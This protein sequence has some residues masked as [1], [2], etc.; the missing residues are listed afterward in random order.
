MA[1]LAPDEP[2]AHYQLG[3]LYKFAGKAAE[4]LA[5]FER[6]VRL[7]PRLAAARFQLYNMYR[8][9]GRTEEAAATLE[10]FQTLKKQSAG[11]AI[12]EDVDWCDY[13][14]IYDPPRPSAPTPATPE[15][16]FEDRPL[17]GAFDAENRGADRSSIPP[18]PARS[19]C[20]RGLHKACN[21]IAA[22]RTASPMPA[23]R[24]SPESSRSLP[25][26]LTTTA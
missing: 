9:A 24:V 13:A 2:I 8:Q 19:I 3:T 11:A 26:I 21:S 1:A 17:E 20:W 22:A 4:A 5:A 10:V 16:E 7:D 18:A 25:A 6:A 15:S 12:P 14:E 23:S